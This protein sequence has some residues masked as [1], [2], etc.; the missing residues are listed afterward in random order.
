M[1]VNS[2]IQA[3]NANVSVKMAIGIYLFNNTLVSLGSDRHIPISNAAWNRDVR[4]N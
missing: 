3:L 1:V 4:I 2:A